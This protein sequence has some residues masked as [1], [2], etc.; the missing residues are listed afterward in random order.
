M[1]LYFKH[2]HGRG[3]NSQHSLSKVSTSRLLRSAIPHNNIFQDVYFLFLYPLYVSGVRGSVVVKVLY[4]KPEGHG[5]D[6]R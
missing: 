4:Y 3:K 5:F 6:T 2:I 1:K